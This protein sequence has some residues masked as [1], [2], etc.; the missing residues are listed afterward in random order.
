MVHIGYKIHFSLCTEYIMAL[1]DTKLRSLHGKPYTGSPELSDGDGLGVRISPLGAMTFQFRYRWE[2]KAQRIS[3]G[4]YPAMGLK[5]ARALVGE[6]RLLYDKGINPR[7]HFDLKHTSSELTVGECL[8]HWMDG[9]VR[10]QL[11]KNTINLYEAVVVKHMKDAFKGRPISSISVKDWISFFG[12]QEKEGQKRARMMFI[13]AKSAFSWCLRRQLIDRCE[14]MRI[15]PKDVGQRSETGERVLTFNELAQIW[16]AIE[17]TRASPA[18]KMLHQL[19][20]MWGCRLSELRLSLKPE[21]DMK[22]LV[23]TVPKEHSKMGNVIRRPIFSQAQP[24][25]ERLMDA[26]DNVMFPGYDINEPISIAAANRYIGRIRDDMEGVG[27]WRAH[28][29]RRTVVTRL[30]EEGVAPHVTEKMMGHDLGGVMAVYNKHDWLE[31]QRKGYEIFADKLFWHI[32]N[33]K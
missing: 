2:G 14:M 32:K 30:S 29:F 28:D 23:W 31:E 12:A 18:N 1:S 26:Y 17:R 25:I 9:Y 3:L 8:E 33:V 22:E 16:I 5:D 15:E 4:K 27:Y 10:T 24:M 21:F 11:R 7:T 20:M 6:L 13:Q 19:V